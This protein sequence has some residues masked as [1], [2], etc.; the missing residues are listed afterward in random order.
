MVTTPT[1]QMNRLFKKRP[2]EG[3]LLDIQDDVV[4]ADIYVAIKDGFNI[5]D[6]SRAIQQQVSR[7]ISEMVGMQVGR[8]NVHVEDI[9]FPA[10]TEAK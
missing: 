4:Y 7:A 6:V 8:V 10:E 5:R 1:V 3:V 9:D 2:S